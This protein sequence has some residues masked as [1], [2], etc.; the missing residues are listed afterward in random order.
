VILKQA[1]QQAREILNSGNIENASLAA[2]VLLGYVLKIDKVCLYQRFEVTINPE[3]TEALQKLLE[4]HLKGEP[5]AYIIGH[6]EFYGIEIY[7]DNR[8]LIP[9]PETELLV[10]KAIEIARNRITNTIADIGT[11]SGA[12][13]IA[14]AL[15]LP[16]VKIFATDISRQALNLATMNS[17]KYNLRDRIHL[18]E[19]DM[20]EPLSESVDLIVANLP[21]IKELDLNEPS[22]KY[23]PILALNGG[24]DGLDQINRFVPGVKNKLKTGGLFL[25][26]IGS[27]QA[28]P[29]TRLI[30]QQTSKAKIE[31]FRDYSGIKRVILAQNI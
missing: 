4:R 11:G 8:V 9:R 19:G 25:M 31:V 16:S 18:L 28:D 13:A 22:I 2:E 17:L 27:G 3:E 5:I 26:E 12:I 20:L 29:V 15:N 14:L 1:L 21:Y 7:V 6:K 30:K 23:E 24:A 10:D